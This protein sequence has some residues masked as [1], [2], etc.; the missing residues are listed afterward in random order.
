MIQSIPYCENSAKLFA[1]VAD[2]PWAVFLDSCHP[3]T[4]VARFDIIAFRPK[5]TLQ[6]FEHYNL[7]THTD[8]GRTEKI[9]G[10]PFDLLNNLLQQYFCEPASL[11]DFLP[12]R[13][14]A[15]GYFS[16]DLCRTLE[17]IPDIADND[18]PTAMMQIGIYHTF[19]VVDHLTKN[20]WFI[21]DNIDL[22]SEIF[23]SQ[24]SNSHRKTFQ[25]T[26]AFTSNFTKDHY[27]TAFKK[28]KSYLYEGDC[29][30]INLA[31]R[32]EASFQGATYSVYQH[33]RTINPAP[34]S[35]YLNFP[36]TTVMSF[37]PEQF[38]EKKSN[39]ISTSPIKG[40]APRDHDPLIDNANKERLLDS[41]KDKAENLMIVDLMR[42]DFGRVCEYGSIHVNK[43]FSL[44]SFANVHHLVS[45]IEGRLL[46]Q[47]S[48]LDLLKACFP[49]GSITGAPKIRAME[50][51]EELEPNR[52]N[53]YCG[54]IGFINQD[55]DMHLNI[56]IRTL[57]THRNTIYCAAGG[58]IVTDSEIEAE[59]QESLD[60]ITI[61][62]KALADY[63]AG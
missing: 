53:I 57:Y 27:A 12:F 14:G 36:E 59:Y 37:S 28:I 54:S 32:F 3:F 55:G 62:L 49:G 10:A 61:L 44:E 7:I 63:C 58:A 26:S 23:P 40:T 48:S 33:L 19:I 31:Q 2:E 34:F 21:S 39:K 22:F 8:D 25:L 20:S 35:A 51:I 60:K 47:Y 30:Q 29:Y 13:G 11:P 6:S 15:I 24:N 46:K 41:E 50:I 1:S 16:Y 18:C 43:L 17:T 5:V 9:T 52:R 56:A 45:H 38:I 42:N 4:E